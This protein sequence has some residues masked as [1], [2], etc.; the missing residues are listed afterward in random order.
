MQ[1]IWCQYMLHYWS[2]KANAGMG[3][4]KATMYCCS[5]CAYNVSQNFSSWYLL[6]RNLMLPIHTCTLQ[7]H[8]R[9]KEANQV[10]NQIQPISKLLQVG[11]IT[12]QVTGSSR[13]LVLL[14][15]HFEQNKFLLTS[16]PTNRLHCEQL[17]SPNLILL[18][19]TIT[20]IH[21][22]SLKFSIHTTIQKLHHPTSSA[23]FQDK[24]TIPCHQ[25]WNSA[26]PQCPKIAEKNE[27]L[28]KVIQNS[29]SN[30]SRKEKCRTTFKVHDVFN[31]IDYNI[32][33]IPTS[34]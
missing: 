24:V 13:L 1:Q 12:M 28:D 2:E 26:H 32:M 10:C 14:A 5:S 23:S 27:K 33:S 8:S 11:K 34:T 6:A 18:S 22:L 4:S 20:T 25:S 16:T 17:L 7:V 29:N 3:I 30:P 15:T 9:P 21:P 31:T 19:P